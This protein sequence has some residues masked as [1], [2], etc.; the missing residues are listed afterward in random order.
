M[1]G[2]QIIGGLTKTAKMPGLSLSLQARKT[3]PVGDK[4]A[5]IPGT[6]CFSCYATGNFYTFPGTI[7]AQERRLESLLEAIANPDHGRRWSSGLGTYLDDAEYNARRQVKRIGEPSAESLRLYYAD[8]AAQ[9]RCNAGAR[10]IVKGGDPAKETEQSQGLAVAAIAARKACEAIKTADP[11]EARRVALFISWDNTRHFRWHDSG[12]VISLEHML[13]IDRAV[14]LSPTVRHWLPTQERAMI[15][16]YVEHLKAEGLAIPANLTIRVSSPK[17]DAHRLSKIEGVHAS[18]VSTDGET[19]GN[20]CP[21][22]QQGGI[23][24]DCRACWDPNPLQS[25]P[26]H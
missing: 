25:Y 8:Q 5:E 14:R 20:L 26:F 4:L 18:S 16:R 2:P 10:R 17:I 9:A 21:A 15:K 6:P 3:C 11:V 7:A 23:C 13:L 12:D 19:P 24:G 22:Y 1:I